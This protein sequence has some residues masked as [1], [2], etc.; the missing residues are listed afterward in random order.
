MIQWG[1][2]GG[3]QELGRLI[4]RALCALGW[5][6]WVVIRTGSTRY[7]CCVRCKAVR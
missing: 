2:Q 4:L 7:Q 5:H 1:H 3:A 6:D